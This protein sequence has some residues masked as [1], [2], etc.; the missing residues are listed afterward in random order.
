MTFED[1][2]VVVQGLCSKAEVCTSTPAAESCREAGGADNLQQHMSDKV[3]EEVMAAED[4]MAA[5]LIARHKLF[6]AHPDLWSFELLLALE[7]RTNEQS[8]VID[9]GLTRGTETSLVVKA[10]ESVSLEP[11]R[12]AVTSLT[13]FFGRFNN[14]AKTGDRFAELELSRPRGILMPGTEFREEPVAFGRKMLPD[15]RGFNLEPT[16]LH[17]GIVLVKIRML[18]G[19]PSS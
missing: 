7:Y 8:C 15:P 10:P 4:D 17:N 19:S 11:A 6:E 1:V 16:W 13:R 9:S 5:M 18:M 12:L 3:V 2:S 14:G